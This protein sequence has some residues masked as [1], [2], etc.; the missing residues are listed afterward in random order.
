MQQQHCLSLIKISKSLKF[1]CFVVS[2]RS[3]FYKKFKQ[4]KKCVFGLLL[5]LKKIAFKSY[6]GCYSNPYYYIWS[7]MFFVIFKFHVVKKNNRRRYHWSIKKVEVQKK[8]KRI[9]TNFC[10]KTNQNLCKPK[11]FKSMFFEIFWK[12][13][14]SIII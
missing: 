4:I 10:C 6:V 5:F 8:N 12:K 14:C 9:K 3:P 2:C 11:L 7:N 1:L 13:Q